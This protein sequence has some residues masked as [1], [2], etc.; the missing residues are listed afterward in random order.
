[1]AADRD[2]LPLAQASASSE[3]GAQT[4]VPKQPSRTPPERVEIPGYEIVSELGRGGMGVVYKAR[5]LSLNRLVALKM[6]LAGVHADEQEL[7]RFRAEAEM[8]ARLQH[9]HIVQIHEIGEHAG[10]PYFALEFVEGGTLADQLDGTPWA[11]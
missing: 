9:P 8:V 7:S 11:A 1:D 6:V 4:I 5:Q 3:Q 10:R 2:T